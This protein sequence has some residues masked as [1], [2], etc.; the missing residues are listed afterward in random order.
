MAEPATRVEHVAL[1]R[2]GL[3]CTERFLFGADGAYARKT[4][5]SFEDTAELVDLSPMRSRYAV[6][7]H[8]PGR[9]ELLD[10]HVVR[11]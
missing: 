10:E 11:E 4:G 9:V 7:E 8:P 5:C 1:E 3:H 6:V 2:Q